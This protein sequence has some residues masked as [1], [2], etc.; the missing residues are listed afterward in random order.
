MVRSILENPAA[1]Q[2]G[3]E[4]LEKLPANLPESDSSLLLAFATGP[5]PASMPETIWPAFANDILNALRRQETAVNPV[6]AL[7]GVFENAGMPYT[8]RD[9]AIQHI[10]A[11]LADPRHTPTP[12]SARDGLAILWK[13]ADS[14]EPFAGTALCSL[15]DLLDNRPGFVDATRLDALAAVVA[16]DPKT[17]K[18]T[19]ITAL[20]I[21]SARRLAAVLPA[22]RAAASDAAEDPSIRLSAIAFIGQLG[23]AQDAALLDSITRSPDADRLRDAVSAAKGKLPASAP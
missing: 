14:G 9:Y 5:R 19:R 7:Q 13:A 6:P 15:L 3:L 16:A 18:F 23:H 17:N 2:S 10:G 21:A 8:L 20:Q 1:I 11:W 22:A 12:I 4:A